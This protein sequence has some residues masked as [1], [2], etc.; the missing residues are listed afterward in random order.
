MSEIKDV[1]YTLMAMCNQLTPL[2]FKR[3]IEN[4]AELQTFKRDESAS[5]KVDLIGDEY[6]GQ[7]PRFAVVTVVT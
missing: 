7:T 3:L 6:D 5:H 4:T 2:P 1:G